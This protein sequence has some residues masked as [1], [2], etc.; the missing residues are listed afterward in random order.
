MVVNITDALT[1]STVVLNGLT[2][3][4]RGASAD[5]I[6]A[7]G[8]EPVTYPFGPAGWAMAVWS[9]CADPG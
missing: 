3:A 7:T 4:L 2:T 5:R 9:S 1:V 6:S 8:R